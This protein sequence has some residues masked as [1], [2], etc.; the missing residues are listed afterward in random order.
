MLREPSCE[1]RSRTSSRRPCRNL[2]SRVGASSSVMV[3]DVDRLR[4]L[5]LVVKDGL[6]QLAVVARYRTLAGSE[7]MRLRPAQ[8]DAN[9]EDAGLARLA[10]TPPGSS[11]T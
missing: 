1:D 8:A 9:A 7:G 6:H 3:C 4:D 11:V 2:C 10:S 5:N